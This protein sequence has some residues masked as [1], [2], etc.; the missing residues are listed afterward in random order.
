MFLCIYENF[1]PKLKDSITVEDI[2]ACDN[3]YLDIFEI[4]E[5]GNT[6]LQLTDGEWT[7]VEKL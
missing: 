3:G 6:V 4:I 2:V 5:N 1:V 7:N